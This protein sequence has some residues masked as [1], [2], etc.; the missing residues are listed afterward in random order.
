MSDTCIGLLYT[1]D[2]EADILVMFGSK[3]FS[4]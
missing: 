1:S 3:A 4:E 2:S